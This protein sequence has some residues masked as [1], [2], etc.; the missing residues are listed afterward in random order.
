MLYFSIISAALCQSEANDWRC[1]G[2]QSATGQL[3][4][5]VGGG[6]PSKR[7]AFRNIRI[8]LANLSTSCVPEVHDP[9]MSVRFFPV[10]FQMCH[11]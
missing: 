2:K 7:G 1:A 8:F 9:L 3:K 5:R 11:G 6:A 4:T 10:L